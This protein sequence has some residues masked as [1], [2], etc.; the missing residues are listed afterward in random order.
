MGRG[1]DKQRGKMTGFDFYKLRKRLRLNQRAMGR[2]MGTFQSTI[3][4][5]E[6]ADA[7]PPVAARFALVLDI[8]TRLG[9]SPEEITARL[10]IHEK[11]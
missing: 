1:P 3:S 6:N 8:V 5:W 2:L 10:G 7:V 9:V 4:R 11:R